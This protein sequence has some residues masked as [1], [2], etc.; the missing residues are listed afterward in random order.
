[1]VEERSGFLTAYR[2]VKKNYAKYAFD[3][4]VARL[5]GGR[6]NSKGSPA[7]YLSDSIPLAILEILVNLDDQA[8]LFEWCLFE[9]LIPDEEIFDL[10]H[11]HLP[12]DWRENPA[13]SSTMAMGDT[14]IEQNQSLALKV[15]SATV[16]M[17]GFNIV[18]NPKNTQFDSMVNG[19]KPEPFEID[20]RLL[21]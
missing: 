20:P 18:I 4:E 19:V 12:N 5:H 9:V 15:P 1:M 11:D 8:S 21:D 6:W 16:P 10:P 7:V 17:G 2:I 14:W 13:P 3:G